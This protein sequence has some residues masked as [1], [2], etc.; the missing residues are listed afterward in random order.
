MTIPDDIEPLL[1]SEDLR[2]SFAVDESYCTAA[3]R[4]FRF[5]VDEHGFHIEDIIQARH[6]LTVIFRKE[7]VVVTI[8]TEY[9]CDRWG[10]VGVMRGDPALR[11]RFQVYFNK[12]LA[13]YHPDRRLP[14]FPYE[15][16]EEEFALWSSLLADN[17]DEIVAHVL[18]LAGKKQGK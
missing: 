3:I 9:G 16:R 1:D 2:T 7:K 18:E 4:A 5:L 13:P 11:R 14:R 12:L 6:D 15:D 10:T 17:W 8:S